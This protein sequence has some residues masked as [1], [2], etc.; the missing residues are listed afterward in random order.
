MALVSTVVNGIVLGTHYPPGF[1]DSRVIGIPKDPQHW[2]QPSSWRP[3]AMP[4]GIYR[5]T[6]RHVQH[7]LSGFLNEI[8]SPL[9]FGVKGASTASATHYLQAHMKLAAEFTDEPAVGMLDIKNA[10]GSLPHRLLFA[11]LERHAFP[12]LFQQLMRYVYHQALYC[13]TDGGPAFRNV[14]GIRQGCPVS[15][16]LFLLGIDG[17]LQLMNHPL[18]IAYVDDI[19]FVTSTRRR[20]RTQLRTQC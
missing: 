5:I 8:V 16:A 2:D 4:T 9:Q 7:H 13:L 14:C 17:V 3:I 6:L 19:A 12:P 20:Q 15:V 11:L 18:P 10:F 1:A